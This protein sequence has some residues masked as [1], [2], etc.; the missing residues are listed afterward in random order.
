MNFGLEL[1]VASM[2]D[3]DGCGVLIMNLGAWT[4]YLRP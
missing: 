2:Q 1:L 4:E 3:S